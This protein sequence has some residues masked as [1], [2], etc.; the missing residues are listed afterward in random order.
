M[1]NGHIEALSAKHNSLDRRISAELQR[2][3]PD[4]MLIAELKKQK[5]R[6]KDELT[7]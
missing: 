5:L 3:L 1:Q 6:V 2:P 7:G 4:H